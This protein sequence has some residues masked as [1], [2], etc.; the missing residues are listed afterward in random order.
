M[1][2][3]QVENRTVKISYL[4]I[5]SLGHFPNSSEM[6]RKL[7]VSSSSFYRQLKDRNTSFQKTLDEVRTEI[8]IKYLVKTNLTIL[9]A[10]IDL[11][12]TCTGN[13]ITY[14]N[15]GRPTKIQTYFPINLFIGWGYPI[16]GRK[17]V[18]DER[19]KQ[20]IDAVHLCLLEKPFHKTSIKD[21]AQKAGLNHGALHYYF[22][23]KEEILLEYIDHTQKKFDT[24]YLEYL[25]KEFIEPNT[26]LE[27]LH[28]I[29]CWM[30]NELAFQKEYAKI[31]TEIWAHAQYNPNVM[32]KVKDM[33]RVWADQLVAEVN[34]AETSDSEAR[35]IS[36][37]ILS[38]LEGMS[39]MSTIF[40]KEDLKYDFDFNGFLKLLNTK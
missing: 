5:D 13:L 29:W 36:L 21:I 12:L 18:R 30:L 1:H 4:K 11:F 39:L 33:Y 40:S 15:V 20:I 37:T 32:K 24:I 9:S 14:M 6:A 16:M 34:T 3:S 25:K 17:P 19:R 23:S 26:V 8:A 7:G 28:E 27:R 31:Y 10:F 35:K 38:L 2:Q 22:K